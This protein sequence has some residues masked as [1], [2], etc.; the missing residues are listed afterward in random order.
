MNDI[1]SANR[2]LTD[3]VKAVER[4]VGQEL[5]D[6]EQFTQGINK[7]VY[8]FATH[9]RDNEYLNGA[10][11]D[12]LLGHLDIKI[13]DI[14]HNA[15]AH[16]DVPFNLSKEHEAEDLRVKMDLLTRDAKAL[17]DNLIMSVDKQL[18]A[19]QTGIEGISD[20]EF[21]EVLKVVT[22]ADD[23]VEDYEVSNQPVFTQGIQEL[24]AP[25]RTEV[26]VRSSVGGETVYLKQSTYSTGLLVTLKDPKVFLSFP[27]SPLP[28]E[29][30]LAKR[31]LEERQAALSREAE[32][33]IEAQNV[34]EI[35]KGRTEDLQEIPTQWNRLDTTQRM[36]VESAYNMGLDAARGVK[37][38]LMLYKIAQEK[39]Y[40]IP[41]KFKL[42]G[43]FGPTSKALLKTVLEAEGL[44]YVED[45]LARNL[46]T[47]RVLHHDTFPQD[48][49]ELFLTAEEIN[50]PRYKFENKGVYRGLKAEQVK[51]R[52]LATG[53]DIQKLK[54]EKVA[55]QDLSP[56]I[57]AVFPRVLAV[58]QKLTADKDLQA[59][60]LATMVLETGLSSWKDEWGI[61]RGDVKGYVNTFNQ[62]LPSVSNALSAYSP[63]PLETTSAGVMQINYKTAQAIL[64]DA[65][66]AYWSKEDVVRMLAS[67]IEFSTVMAF[68]V[69][70]KNQDDLQK[71]ER[72]MGGVV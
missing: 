72:Q 64:K 7:A 30:D 22:Q 48:N 62:N 1:V 6:Q 26:L 59:S 39:G 25:L 11:Q 2:E 58:L 66:G 47:L 45:S 16:F 29:G 32:D 70:K 46:K 3:T 24:N 69:F 9:I 10:E 20:G 65:T 52:L 68:L 36:A 56:E 44:S 67:S 31:I 13:G 34:Q 17:T 55:G 8:T 14:I 15:V 27:L 23:R 54:A 21:A 50:D 28:T 49:N 60:I 12:L 53:F 71:M 38:Q 4:S 63:V 57:V 41:E 18:R 42:D 43:D 33:T 61:G 51:A 19:K 37:M 40:V 35:L 5:F